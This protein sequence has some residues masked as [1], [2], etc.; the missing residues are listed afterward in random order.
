MRDYTCDVRATT[1]GTS[2]SHEA[3]GSPPLMTEADASRES[4]G[5]GNQIRQILGGAGAA[6]RRGRGQTRLR[7]V[8]GSVAR[9]ADRFHSSLDGRAHVVGIVGIAA[10]ARPPDPA[11]ERSGLRGADVAGSRVAAA[12]VAS[13]IL[14]EASLMLTD[15]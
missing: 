8:C 7:F 15:A 5:R 10:A 4:A 14:R 9:S 2:V 3:E 6:P 11:G 12:M 13:G 1:L